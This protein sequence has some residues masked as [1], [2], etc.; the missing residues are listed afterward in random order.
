VSSFLRFLI[1]LSQWKRRRCC[2]AALRFF[3]SWAQDRQVGRSSEAVTDCMSLGDWNPFFNCRGRGTLH[4]PSLQDRTRTRAHIHMLGFFWNA[5]LRLHS[6]KASAVFVINHLFFGCRCIKTSWL[7]P[8]RLKKQP[9]T[10]HASGVDSFPALKKGFFLMRTKYLY[11][12]TLFKIC[13]GW[14]CVWLTDWLTSN[15]RNG[16]PIHINSQKCLGSTIYYVCIASKVDV[17]MW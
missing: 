14:E 15:Y 4:A 8:Q 10:W 12:Y 7:V 6:F 9:Q 2:H 13:D 3:D 5:A 17:F 1:E 11:T 16:K